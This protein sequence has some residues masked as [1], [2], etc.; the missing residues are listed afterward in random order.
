MKIRTF[1]GKLR[2]KIL[3]ILLGRD[4]FLQVT[5]IREIINK[6]QSIV[7]GKIEESQSNIQIKISESQD[8]IQ[9]KLEESQS[10]VQGKIEES[11]SNVRIKFE[12]VFKRIDTIYYESNSYFNELIKHIHESK[13]IKEINTKTFAKYRNIYKNC[14]IIIMGAGPTLKYY[15]PIGNCIIIGTNGVVLYDKVKLDFLFVQDVNAMNRYEKEIINYDCKKFFSFWG[16]F[17]WT[18]PLKYKNIPNMEEYCNHS[19]GHIGSLYFYHGGE[20]YASHSIPL[21]ICNSPL[22][23]FDSVIFPAVQFALWTYPKRIYVVGC[24]CSRNLSKE[25]SSYHFNESIAKEDKNVMPIEYVVEGW[26]KIKEFQQTYYPDVEMISINPVFLKG[27][28]KDEF[29]DS[30]LTDKPDADK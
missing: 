21:D 20:Y 15:E 1:F 23:D 6:S 13:R 10:I 5:S 19:V 11:Q 18:M 26:K 3:R 2:R 7:Q 9:N 4:L 29:T 12:E 25:W 24:D 30:Y 16:S 22:S 14:E 17:N 8:I 28:F 27:L